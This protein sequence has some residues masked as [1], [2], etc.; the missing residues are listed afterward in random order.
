[1]TKYKELPAFETNEFKV[2]DMVAVYGCPSVTGSYHTGSHHD[3]VHIAEEGEILVGTELNPR[4]GFHFKQC[5]K[6]VE[7]E[8]R[9][10]WLNPVSK[11]YVV[12]GEIIEYKNDDGVPNLAAWIKVR[13]VI[14]E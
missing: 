4:L 12:A 10:W 14:E 9:E 7:V 13:E 8:P 6:L 3:V 2:G 11:T 5:R 1:M